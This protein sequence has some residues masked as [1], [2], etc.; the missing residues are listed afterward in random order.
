MTKLLVAAVAIAA[1]APAAT[2]PHHFYVVVIDNLKF[3]ALPTDPRVGDMIVWRNRDMF[4]H[5]A[6]ARDGSFDTDLPANGMG[7]TMLTK[8]GTIRFY[9]KYHPGMTGAFTVRK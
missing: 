8:S 4:R 7:K 5:S 3:G 1:A 6:T 2:A 9:C